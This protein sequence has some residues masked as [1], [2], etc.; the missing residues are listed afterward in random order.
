MHTHP[1][2]GNYEDSDEEE[3]EDGKKEEEDEEPDA[4]KLDQFAF[5]DEEGP[6]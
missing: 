4:A 2:F 3:S 5:L 6:A 1:L